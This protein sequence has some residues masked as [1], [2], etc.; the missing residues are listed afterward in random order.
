LRVWI[1]WGE[2]K[3]KGGLRKLERGQSVG[4]LERGQSVEKS[5]TNNSTSAHLSIFVFIIYISRMLE[6]STP[7]NVGQYIYSFINSSKPVCKFGD[8]NILK[9]VILDGGKL[10]EYQVWFRILIS[11]FK[12]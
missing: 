10:F 7:R 12:C 5:S 8:K 6:W 4:K 9:S 1:D 3:M 2:E 11:K